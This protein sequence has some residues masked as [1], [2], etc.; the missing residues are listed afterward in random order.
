MDD[1]K[2]PQPLSG[3]DKLDRIEQGL[4]PDDR[5]PLDRPGEPD[6]TAGTGGVNKVQ[7]ELSR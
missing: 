1:G 4:E 6:G 3:A 2:K 7:D 5:T